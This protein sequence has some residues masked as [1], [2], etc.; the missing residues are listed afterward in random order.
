VVIDEL[1]FFVLL[2]TFILEQFGLC[3]FHVKL[4]IL[5]EFLPIIVEVEVLS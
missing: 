1:N 2:F 3:M 5:L 4:C